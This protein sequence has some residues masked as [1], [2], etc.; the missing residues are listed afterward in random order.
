MA[1]SR[2][3]RECGSAS[4]KVLAIVPGPMMPQASGLDSVML[5]LSDLWG[6]GGEIAEP[7][8]EMRTGQIAELAFFLHLGLG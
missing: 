2:P 4:A 5:A 3:V 1:A 8:E 6:G 7:I